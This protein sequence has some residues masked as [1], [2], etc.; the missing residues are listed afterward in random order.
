MKLAFEDDP[1]LRSTGHFVFELDDP[2]LRPFVVRVDGRIVERAI[3]GRYYLDKTPKGWPG[4][5]AL[6]VCSGPFYT[7]P[8]RAL[9]MRARMG[10]LEAKLRASHEKLQKLRP[11]DDA[12]EV[13]LRAMRDFGP[14]GE[15]IATLNEMLEEENP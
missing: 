10:E 1:T 12:Y 13:N 9:F 11:L 5:L 7:P 4:S 15:I 14:T 8:V 3:D 6:E 2:P